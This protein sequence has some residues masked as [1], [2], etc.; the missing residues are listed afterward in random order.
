VFVEAKRKGM[1]KAGFFVGFLAFNFF[2]ALQ[3]G[4]AEL[5]SR[6]RKAFCKHS[7]WGRG[8]VL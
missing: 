1:Q 8:R 6:A 5:S 2:I 4:F 3:F 7:N